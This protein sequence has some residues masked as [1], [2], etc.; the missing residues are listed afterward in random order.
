MRYVV[1]VLKSHKFE[2]SYVGLT[3]NIERR[4]KEHNSGKSNYTKKYLPWSMIYSEECDNLI[5]ARKREK[6][7]KSSVGRKFLKKIFEN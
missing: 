5:E 1:Y 6:Y 3:Q 4:L 2:K 7:F